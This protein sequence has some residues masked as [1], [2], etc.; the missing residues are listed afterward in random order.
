MPVSAFFDIGATGAEYSPEELALISCCRGMSEAHRQFL[1]KM[2]R[3]LQQTNK[4]AAGR[5]TAVRLLKKPYAE[6]ETAACEERYVRD[7]PRTRRADLLFLVRGDGMAPDYPDGCIVAVRRTADVKPG[8]TALFSADG[9]LILRV[10]QADGLHALNPAYPLMRTDDGEIRPVGLAAG[11]VN[12]ADFAD[13][14][15]IAA[16]EARKQ[17]AR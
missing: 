2:V 6:G 12:D 1:V 13:D 9:A 5:V 3:E 15:E 10:L 8:E 11:I 16:F 14:A 7:T 4:A 17:A